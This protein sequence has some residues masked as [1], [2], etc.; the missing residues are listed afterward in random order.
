MQCV[1][2][3]VTNDMCE[4]ES[5]EAK[6][7]GLAMLTEWDARAFVFEAKLVNARRRLDEWG[8][9]QVATAH[10]DKNGQGNDMED[11]E[12]HS[13]EVCDQGHAQNHG[14]LQLKEKQDTENMLTKD[15]KITRNMIR[16]DVT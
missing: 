2:A 6:A 13:D 4:R 7:Q 3:Y 9:H 5:E 1:F 12:P 11:K 8:N 10:S 15:C 14:Y 16:H